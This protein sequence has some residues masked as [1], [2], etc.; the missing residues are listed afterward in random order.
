MRQPYIF[1]P[2]RKNQKPEDFFRFFVRQG[3]PFKKE[4]VNSDRTDG[5]SIGYL[6]ICPT[7][8]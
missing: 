4:Q 5:L 1:L 6:L 7:K 3:L 8:R 2:P